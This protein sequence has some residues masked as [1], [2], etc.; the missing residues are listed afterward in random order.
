MTIIASCGHVLT[1]DDGEDGM[2][3]QIAIK[4]WSRENTEQVCYMNVCTP[5][6][7]R[8]RDEGV[9]LEDQA[10]INAYLFGTT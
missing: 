4:S 8:Y 7:Q 10:A 3:T 5:C 9:L 1:D 2:G 6:I